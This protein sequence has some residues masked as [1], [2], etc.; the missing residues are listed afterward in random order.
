M[1]GPN[2]VRVPRCPV[3]HNRGAHRA[4]GRSGAAVGFVAVAGTASQWRLAHAEGLINA[5]L[6]IALAAALFRITLS[7]RSE[8]LIFWGLVGM[9]W[10]NLFGAISAALGGDDSFNA[11]VVKDNPIAM[12]FYGVAALGAFVAFV[13]SARCA[14]REAQ[15]PE[16]DLRSEEPAS[17]AEP[18]GRRP[19]VAYST[20][21]AGAP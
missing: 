7:R 4:A 12:L 17:V 16:A 1:D 2:R 13:E 11:N 5:I 15:R 20:K 21:R 19:C 14:W 6:V 3:C 8:T 18:V 10:G 9:V